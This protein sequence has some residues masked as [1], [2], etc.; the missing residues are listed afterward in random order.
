VSDLWH[1][2]QCG[3]VI[4]PTPR[5][6]Y[7]LSEMRFCRAVG[8]FGKGTS[9]DTLYTLRDGMLMPFVSSFCGNAIRFASLLRFG[10]FCKLNG[11]RSRTSTVSFCNTS[12][13]GV[14]S[15]AV[16]GPHSRILRSH[17][18]SAI[19]R[20]A[21]SR[22]IAHRLFKHRSRRESGVSHHATL[23]PGHAHKGRKTN[24][25]NWRQFPV[26]SSVLR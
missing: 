3:Y 5:D 23:N 7:R 4:R 18:S 2:H 22:H 8:V 11:S 14:L 13:D 26:G 21:I 25:C 12:R 19:G 9:D 1:F 24:H 6:G 17:G 15:F 20:P 10:R 16:R